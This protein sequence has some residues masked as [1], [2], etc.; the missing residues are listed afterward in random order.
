MRRGCL[1]DGVVG[2]IQA[3]AG[4]FS[5]FVI[6]YSGGWEWGQDLPSTDQL[7]RT[8]ITGH[9]HK[10]AGI[11]LRRHRVQR[12]VPLNRIGARGLFLRL[13][14]KVIEPSNQGRQRGIRTMRHHAPFPD[15]TA[16]G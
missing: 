1:T 15:D 6:L 5:Y 16:L 3:A 10:A 8:A 2:M 11:C 9:G 7:Y 14:G 12:T 4:F 13:R